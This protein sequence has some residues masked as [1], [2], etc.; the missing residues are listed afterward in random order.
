MTL[1]PDSAA[2]RP[3]LGSRTKRALLFWLLMVL[4]AVVLWKMSSTP[5]QEGR[6][7]SYS[8]FLGQVDKQNVR[9]VTFYFGENTA[10]VT[11]TLSSTGERV[12]SEIPK[13]AIPNLTTEL[14]KQGVSV[15]VREGSTRGEWKGLLLNMLPLVILVIFWIFMMRRMGQRWG[16]Q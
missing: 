16:R 6:E 1:V 15:G 14:R 7:L 12:R 2:G 11:G 5:R 3:W 9:D 8:D 4:L 13:E 10:I